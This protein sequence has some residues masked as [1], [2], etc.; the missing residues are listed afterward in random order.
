MSQAKGLFDAAKLS[1]AIEVLTQD[2]K[3]APSDVAL[4]T[5]LFEL[6]CFAG[7]WDRA[8]R[9]LDVVG[10]QSAQAEVGVMVYR[11][12]IKAERARHRLLPDGLQPHF[13]S[14]PP[15]YVDM[16]LDA[17]NRLREGNTG[18][19]RKTLDTAEEERPAFTG[20]VNGRQ[21]QDFRDYDDLFGPVFELIV[22]DKYTWLPIEHVVR[23]EIEPPKQ[24]RDL[25]WVGANIE[26]KDNALKAFL[27]ALYPGTHAHEN[28]MARLGRMT[29]WKQVGEELYQGAGLHL[30]AVDGEEQPV[31]EVRSIEFDAAAAETQS[32]AS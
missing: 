20:R 1:E 30:F 21:F 12:L 25:L 3:A 32:A 10:H 31:L 8:E 14:E 16:H 17:I 19:A 5:F 22:Q 29:D 13:L 15:A 27:P 9:Q 23:V 2:V 7:E 28:E 24:F 11:N 6:L 4:R 18:E 26:T